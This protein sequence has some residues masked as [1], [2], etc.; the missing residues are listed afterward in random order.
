MKKIFALIILLLMSHAE[1]GT[2]SP[3][4]RVGRKFPRPAL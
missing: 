4:L 1:A 3:E 2:W